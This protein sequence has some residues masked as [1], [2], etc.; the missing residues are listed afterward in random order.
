MTTTKKTSQ[1]V[2]IFILFWS[3]FSF[4]TYSQANEKTWK[5][6][7]LQGEKAFESGELLKALDFANKAYELTLE[8]WGPGDIKT[9]RAMV[10]LARV[11]NLLGNSE[12]SSNLLDKALKIREASLG[13]AYVNIAS[14][15]LAQADLLMG[16]NELAEAQ[17]LLKSAQRIYQTIYGDVHPVLIEILEKRAVINYDLGREADSISFY[18]QALSLFESIYGSEHSQVVSL[19][20]GL[21][22]VHLKKGDSLIAQTLLYRSMKLCSQQR[23]VGLFEEGETNLLLGYLYVENQKP[24]RSEKYFNSCIEI[25][26]EKPLS[27][28]VKLLLAEAYI[29]L[30]RVI[31]VRKFDETV[32]LFKKAISLYQELGEVTLNKQKK[33]L[34]ELARIYNRKGKRIEANKIKER[35]LSLKFEEVESSNNYNVKKPVIKKRSPFKQ[36]R[37]KQGAIYYQ[38]FCV[39]CHQKSATGVASVIPPLK[40]SDYL[41]EDKER[42]IKVLLQGLSGPITVNDKT[43]HSDMPKLDLTDEQISAILTFIRSTWNESQ[44]FISELEVAKVRKALRKS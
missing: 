34:M 23:S 36:D 12:S 22:K 3:T 10:I 19:L 30:A 28:K 31:S 32:H 39:G 24:E 2:R 37:I 5:D 21:A 29:A 16:K 41:M 4:C 40:N 42:S 38:M 26:K 27:T 43:Y 18:E 7:L 11:K 8:L 1:W 20:N 17:Y 9:V 44:E 33:T 15:Y 14:I 35:A 25:L 13:D 6:Y